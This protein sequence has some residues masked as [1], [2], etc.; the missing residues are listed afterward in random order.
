MSY[1]PYLYIAVREEGAHE[2]VSTEAKLT[3]V[4]W[5][6]NMRFMRK[7]VKE[8]SGVILVNILHVYVLKFFVKRCKLV[9]L[10]FL[11]QLNLLRLIMNAILHT[12]WLCYWL[13]HLC[14]LFC[15]GI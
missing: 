8:C 13:M 2:I 7:L 15:F 3:A 6:K 5:L 11:F 9:I 1:V 4:S 14:I 10:S 12:F